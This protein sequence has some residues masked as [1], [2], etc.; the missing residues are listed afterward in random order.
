MTSEDLDGSVKAPH[1]WE[2]LMVVLD[3]FS[4]SSIET[5]VVGTYQNSN[6]YPHICFQGEIR[7]IIL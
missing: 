7:K 2:Y 4:H 6:E 3:K 5:Y 1:N